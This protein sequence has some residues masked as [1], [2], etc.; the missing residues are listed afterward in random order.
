[1]S[2]I[3]LE[4]FWSWLL[5][6]PNCIVRAGN[7]ECVLCD[8]EDFHWW[9]GNDGDMLVTQLI[10]GKR[11][12]GELVLEPERAAY[13]EDRGAQEEGEHLFEIIAES[14]NDRYAAYFF[15][16]AH[17]LEGEPEGTHSGAVH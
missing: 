15:V 16:L 10:R 4:T 9:L 14:D 5:E 2:T 11:L 6:H 13:V 12:I 17:G 3:T 7:P 1:M 8:D